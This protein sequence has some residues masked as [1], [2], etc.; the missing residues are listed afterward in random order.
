MAEKVKLS[1]ADIEQAAAFL[2]ELLAREEEIKAQRV[3]TERVL[4]EAFAD[5]VPLGSQRTVD[6]AGIKFIV[7]R[8]LTYKADTVGI[9]DNL[10]DD[11][12]DLVITKKPTFNA[13][14]YKKLEAESPQ[15]FKTV[16]AFVT[17]TESKPYVRVVPP[18]GE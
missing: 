4:A 15:D 12:A 5:E 8:D 17:V 18:K 10:P 9:Y 11:I 3:E 6:K 2:L 1:D 16:Q 13:S 7:K 14:A